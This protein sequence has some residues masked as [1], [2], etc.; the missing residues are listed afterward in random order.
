MMHG[1]RNIKYYACCKF[2][3]CVVTNFTTLLLWTSG[4]SWDT[5]DLGIFVVFFSS[6]GFPSSTSV[7]PCKS[8]CTNAPLLQYHS[9]IFYWHS[10]NLARDSVVKQKNSFLLLVFLIIIIFSVARQP[11]SARAFTFTHTHTHTRTLGRTLWIYDQTDADLYVTTQKFQETDSHK[12]TVFE[13]A[14]PVI[15]RSKTHALVRATA[16]IGSINNN[17]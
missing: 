8:L 4:R 7:F 6:R 15:K 13:P 2:R 11:Q 12:P 10:I 14:I 1:Q 9:Y 17:K 5:F 3:D 16:V